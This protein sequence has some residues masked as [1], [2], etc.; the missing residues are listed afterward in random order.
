MSSRSIASMRAYLD[1][2]MDSILTRL[3]ETAK[4]WGQT[5]EEMIVWIFAGKAM[6]GLKTP[7][8]LTIEGLE[9]C[10]P[11]LN[12]L[13][14]RHIKGCTFCQ[15]VIK[16][17]FPGVLVDENSSLVDEIYATLRPNNCGI[18]GMPSPHVMSIEFGK[19]PCQQ[20]G[21]RF[22]TIPLR[23]ELSHVQQCLFCQ[24][25]IHYQIIGRGLSCLNMYAWQVYPIFGPKSQ[26]HITENMIKRCNCVVEKC[27]S[28]A[29]SRFCFN[30][31][32][33]RPKFLRL[34]EKPKSQL[35]LQ[36][37]LHRMKKFTGNVISAHR[38]A[39]SPFPIHHPWS[40]WNTNDSLLRLLT[41]DNLSHEERLYKE[42]L[43]YPEKT[44]EIIDKL[45]ATFDGY[46][47]MDWTYKLQDRPL[48]WNRRKVTEFIRLDSES[49]RRGISM[50]ELKAIEAE[51]D[52]KIFEEVMIKQQKEREQERRMR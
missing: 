14:Y 25:I 1:E 26:H 4:H 31:L 44:T 9:K 36:I 27:N 51:R 23:N 22:F 15:E 13:Q 34:K 43:E 7:D 21:Q 2:D 38:A 10:W 41:A 45:I 50:E 24:L 16:A 48:L 30:A 3:D 19:S 42:L 28:W 32:R 52:R 6:V 20:G 8:C 17:A 46:E 37:T 18:R 33:D 47:A 49:R 35:K 40:V 39:S 11:Y 12:S 5:R 29:V